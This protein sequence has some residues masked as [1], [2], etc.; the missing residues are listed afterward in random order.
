MKR[1][2]IDVIYEDRDL[3]VVNK[4]RG[5][6]MA[7]GKDDNSKTTLT[8]S[9]RAYIVSKFDGAK[10][11]FAK[12]LHRIDKET[13]G[14]V[15]FAKSKTGLKLVDD[16]KN[17]RVKRV[18]VAV[19]DGA[20]EGEDGTIDHPLAKGDFGYG[21][22]VSVAKKGEGKEAVTHYHVLERYENATLVEARL[23]TG[24]THQIRV[25]LASIGHPIVGDKVYNPYGKIRFPRQA[26]H[27]FRITFY[28]PASAKKIQLKAKVP[29]DM[30]LLI[31]EL[32]G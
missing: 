3:I 26:L 12:P 5:V 16:I 14:I 1:R 17:H 8:H 13:T 15:L 28:H 19:V 11:S 25:H 22:K 21:K 27:S 23:E 32:R 29:R 6:V 7:A 9:V 2:Y 4:P 31:D 24:F 20:I 18:Y 30:E 10:A